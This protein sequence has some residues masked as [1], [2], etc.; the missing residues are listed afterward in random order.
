[1]VHC[2]LPDVK[3][4]GGDARGGEHSANGGSAAG[5]L[6][7]SV[8]L[9]DEGSLDDFDDVVEGVVDA[10]DEGGAHVDVNAAG[11]E[12]EEDGGDGGVPEGEAA[13]GGL[14]HCQRRDSH[15]PLRQQQQETAT[16]DSRVRD[17]DLYQILIVCPL[18]Y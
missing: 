3:A 9:D 11:E 4:G 16:A 7:R 13:A 14:E 5:L 18:N 10:L 8:G 15:E 1:M 2:R 12:E 6:G 17:N